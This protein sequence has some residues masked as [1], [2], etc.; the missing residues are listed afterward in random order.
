MALINNVENQSML[1]VDG[2]I[3]DSNLV[4]TILLLPPTMLKSVDKLIASIGDTLT[5]T[6]VI[7][8]VSLSALTN[9]EFADAIP[10]GTVYVDDSFKLNGTAVVPIIS[11]DTLYYTISSIDILGVATVS[12]Q[13]EVVG[14]ETEG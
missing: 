12:F 5:Y 6:I 3:I 14:G 9:V 7:T 2:V 13:V 4:D 8:N 10:E 1:D 11:E